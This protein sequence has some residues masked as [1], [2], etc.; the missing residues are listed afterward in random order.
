[1]GCAK[2]VL[3]MTCSPLRGRGEFRH[4]K[5]SSLTL[6]KDGAIEMK[7]LSFFCVRLL[8]KL[9]S[10]RIHSESRL[11]TTDQIQ[12][13]YFARQDL[14]TGFAHPKLQGS[15]TPTD[16]EVRKIITTPLYTS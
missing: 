5:K 8:D 16:H 1:M 2:P 3:I 14:R 4:G 13:I 7:S 15:S 9:Y 12:K 11:F 6:E 10:Q